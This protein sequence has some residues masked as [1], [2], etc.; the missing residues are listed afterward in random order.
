M[1]GYPPSIELAKGFL[2]QYT[3]RKPCTLARYTATIKGF[4]KWYGEPMDDFKVKFPKTLP[5]YTEESDVEKLF[6]AIENKKSHKG[7]YLAPV[8]KNACY[9]CRN[10][11]T[12][13]QR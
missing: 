13:V 5:P 1:N 8:S 7:R 6:Q 9:D 11:F 3:N 2:S 10:C 4:M 12:F